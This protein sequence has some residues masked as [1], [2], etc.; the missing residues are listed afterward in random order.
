MFRTFLCVVVAG[1]IASACLVQAKETK[2]DKPGE[3]AEAKEV[4]LVKP[5]KTVKKLPPYNPVAERAK[6][7]TVAGKDNEIDAKE[8][9]AAKGKKNG[10]VRETDTWSGIAKYDKDKNRTISWFEADAYRRAERKIAQATVTTITGQAIPAA[11]GGT[12]RGEGTRR[13]SASDPATI[14]QYDKDG[15]GKLNSAERSAAWGARA[16]GMRQDFMKRYDTDGD[17]KFDEKEQAA[18]RDSFRARMADWGRRAAERRYDKDGDGKLSAEEKAAM[19]TGEAKRT[20]ERETRR[21]EFIAKYDKD[22]DGEISTEE[23]GAIGADFRRRWAERRYD[24]DRDG[25]LSAEEKAAMEAGEAQRAAERA[26]RDKERLEK[27]DKDKDGK[28]SDEERRAMYGDMRGRFGG[29]RRGE[30]KP[31]AGGTK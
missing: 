26:K 22:G 12:G 21:K 29:R 16:E 1:C 31:E 24:K 30:T 13:W 4:K 8:F 17:G 9:A 11:G 5:A 19:E 6:F 23:R 15:D 10:F 25:K 7:F 18:I 2:T 3:K 14:K 27:Y 20:A 28:L